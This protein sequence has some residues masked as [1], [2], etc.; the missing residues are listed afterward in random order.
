MDLNTRFI[1]QS[2]LDQKD[3]HVR[4][5]DYKGD[6][7]LEMEQG[8]IEQGDMVAVIM[9]NGERKLYSMKSQYQ[10]ESILKR[11]LINGM[12]ELFT[13]ANSPSRLDDFGIWYR[14]EVDG[15]VYINNTPLQ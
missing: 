9:E 13:G 7:L 15:R 2:L 10:L 14:D 12:N 1:A 4:V 3:G 5:I 6:P 8:Y 11:R